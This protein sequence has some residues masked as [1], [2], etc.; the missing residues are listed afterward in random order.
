MNQLI[1]WP[2]L[3][4]WLISEAVSSYLSN[5]IQA[6]KLYNKPASSNSI[7]STWLI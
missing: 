7:N 1:D 4:K 6:K 3:T 5:K 2:C